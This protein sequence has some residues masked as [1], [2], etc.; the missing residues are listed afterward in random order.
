M[1]RHRTAD[2]ELDL[3]DLISAALELDRGWTV[4]A[5]CLSWSGDNKPSP[6]QVDKTQAVDGVRGSELIK[7]ALMVCRTCPAQYDCTRYAVQ[8]QMRA[9]T[10]AMGIAN[11]RWL[12]TRPDAADITDAAEKSGTPMEDVVQS[13]R[14]T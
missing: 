7:M 3:G 14:S 1:T 8:G 13:L 11:L 4:R 6:W 10:W 12:Q 2:G 5:S 9:G